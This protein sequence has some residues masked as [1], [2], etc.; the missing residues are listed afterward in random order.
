MGEIPATDPR[1]AAA[2]YQRVFDCKVERTIDGGYRFSTTSGPEPVWVGIVNR[3]KV[4][5]ESHQIAVY[6]VAS[7]D[8]ATRRVHRHGGTVIALTTNANGAPIGL[9]QDT[10]GNQFSIEQSGPGERPL[11]EHA[12]RESDR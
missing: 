1:R 3:W 12:A 5:T 10:E 11:A 4:P 7:V 6:E 2:F 8:E 9:C